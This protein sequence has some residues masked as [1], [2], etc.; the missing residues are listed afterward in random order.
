M[1][2]ASPDEPWDD[3]VADLLALAYAEHQDDAEALRVILRYADRDQLLV[4]CIKLCG[5]LF[6]GAEPG[7]PG[8]RKWVL[9]QVRS[10]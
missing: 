10:P 3:S 2:G 7:H 4:T 6:G 1:S 5:R 8:L 9:E